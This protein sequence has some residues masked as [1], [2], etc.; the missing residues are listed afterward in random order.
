MIV[1]VF[2]NNNNR[3]NIIYSYYYKRNISTMFLSPTEVFIET[4]TSH[5]IIII[6]QGKQNFSLF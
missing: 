2:Q 6:I 3:E 4:A 5:F 1:K